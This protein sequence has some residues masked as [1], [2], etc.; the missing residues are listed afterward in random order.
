METNS[1]ETVYS[2]SE[3]AEQL[4]IQEST[5]RKYCLLLEGEGYSFYRNQ[6]GYRGFLDTDVI[7]LRKL[8]EIKNAGDMTLKRAVKAVMS[9]IPEPV[10]TGPVTEN[11]S[12]Y[13]DLLEEFQAFREQQ[14]KF[15]KELLKQL[16]TQ[17]D[18]IQH[19]L[20]ER[21]QVLTQALRETL[22]TQKLL[23]A[24]QEQE[25]KKKWWQFWK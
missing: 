6:V 25:R 3:V 1:R 12:R 10:I 15:N 24:T 13:N 8:I 4:G 2:S 5:L 16:Q 11:N 7:T 20:K 14:E 9:A 21:D 23:V 22:E 17:Q 19:T 18:Y